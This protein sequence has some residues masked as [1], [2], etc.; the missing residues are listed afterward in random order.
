M[1]SPQIQCHS[2]NIQVSPG[3]RTDRHRQDVAKEVS[4]IGNPSSATQLSLSL[5]WY[6]G[7]Q[8]GKMAESARPRFKAQPCHLE[9][10][11]PQ[12]HYLTSPRLSPLLRSGARDSRSCIKFSDVKYVWKA[13]T[14]SPKGSAPKQYSWLFLQ[15][16]SRR[17]KSNH[18]VVPNLIDQQN[19]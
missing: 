3:P 10:Q 19:H 16:N 7:L 6:S 5:C 13:H 15:F 12:P 14:A 1:T 18:L 4:F 8:E 11:G 17:I 9:A 2:T